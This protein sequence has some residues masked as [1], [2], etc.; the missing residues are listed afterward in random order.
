MMKSDSGGLIR[1]NNVHFYPFQ[2]V[3][4][5]RYV[6]VHVAVNNYND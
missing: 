4:M 2:C 3:V 6:T 1:V 5:D